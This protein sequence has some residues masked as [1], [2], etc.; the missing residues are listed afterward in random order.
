MK[1]I[2]QFQ[3]LQRVERTFIDSVS[4]SSADKTGEA[5]AIEI[6]RQKPELEDAIR[7]IDITDDMDIQDILDSLP[8]DVDASGVSISDTREGHLFIEQLADLAIPAVEDAHVVIESYGMPLLDNI[9]TPGLDGYIHLDL[10]ELVLECTDIMLSDHRNATGEDYKTYM[11]QEDS[12]TLLDITVTHGD[13]TDNYE[14]WVNSFTAEAVQKMSDIDRIDI[15]TDALIPLTIYRENYLANAPVKVFLVTATRRILLHEGAIGDGD[16]Y[17][18]STD[19]P[20]SRI[21]YR[22]NEPFYLEF[23]IAT[24]YSDT[25]RRSSASRTYDWKTVRTPVYRVT[26][27]TAQQYLF[28]NDYG[29]FD[30]IAMTGA[31]VLT[32]EYE[33]EN[34]FRTNSV[35]RAKATRRARYTQNSG[36]LSRQTA[37]VLSQLLL[38]RKIYVYTPGTEPRRIV[39]EEPAAS[40]SSHNP[41]NTITFAWRYAEN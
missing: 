2:N 14:F 41:V 5:A 21:P 38:S 33:L 15:P 26:P 28:L 24:K 37:T 18:I 11:D 35:E 27:A 39:I 23:R 9:Y 17:L 3:E 20:V 10:R 36:P 7:A 25:L 6:I 30:I 8:D 12:G 4:E 34:S 13:K 19:V 29:H 1:H 31:M 40:I 22:M 32:P 16:G